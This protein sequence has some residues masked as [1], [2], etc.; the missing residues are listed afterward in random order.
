MLEGALQ[1]RLWYLIGAS[2]MRRRYARSRLGQLW[3]ILTSAITV[4]TIGLVWSYLWAQPV[5]EILPYIAVGLVVWQLISAILIEFDY[6]VAGQYSLF[7]QSIHAYLDNRLRAG[8]SARRYLFHELDLSAHSFVQ[9]GPSAV[10]LCFVRDPG[11]V[12]DFNLVF[13]D[14]LDALDLMRAISRHRPGREQPDSGSHFPHTCSLDTRA[15]IDTLSGFAALE[16][17]CGFRCNRSR[18]VGR[19]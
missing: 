1:W 10:K 11:C 12:A 8:I 19:A 4:S 9:S 13:V 2:E 7:P 16:P 18:P 14:V 3:I 17:L 6:P 5:R 15:S